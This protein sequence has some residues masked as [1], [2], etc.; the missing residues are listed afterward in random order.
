MLSLARALDPFGKKASAFPLRIEAVLKLMINSSTVPEEP[1]KLIIP[2][3]APFVNRFA[4][5]HMVTWL[6]TPEV[7]VL[8]SSTG[9]LVVTPVQ[10]SP[11]PK[12][13]KK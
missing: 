6:S 8:R 12:S 10:D 1:V 4:S 3:P 9:V 11:L 5:P 13:R 7:E 2:A